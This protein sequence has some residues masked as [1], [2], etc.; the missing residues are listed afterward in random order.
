MP[1]TRHHDP[2]TRARAE[3][4]LWAG[5]LGA[6]TAEALAERER[7]SLA[8]ARGRLVAAHRSGAMAAWRLLRDQPA[9]YTVTRSGLRAADG[10]GLAP[11]RLSAGSARHASACCSAAVALEQAYPGRAVWGEPAIRRHERE[12][13]RALA[14]LGRLTPRGE[15]PVRHRP[16]LLLIGERPE[17][18]PIAVEVEL[19]VKSPE[20][21]RGICLAWARSRHVGGVI[22]LAAPEVLGAL[23][24]SIELV[25]ATDRIVPVALDA[26]DDGSAAVGSLARTIAAGA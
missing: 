3:L 8:S 14:E 24:R 26:L 4:L 2:L 6:V 10:R 15:A 22:Y 7:V 5:G 18:P 20:R 19:T 13:G 17:Q 16:D 25:R 12:R 11:A 1:A 9:I 23:R 21:L